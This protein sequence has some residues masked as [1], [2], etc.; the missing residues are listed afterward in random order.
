M[1]K[2][3]SPK[4]SHPS[5]PLGAHATS[6]MEKLESCRLVF[7]EDSKETRKGRVEKKPFLRNVKEFTEGQEALQARSQI[8]KPMMLG[9]ADK[10]LTQEQ[11]HASTVT[12]PA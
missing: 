7:T 2:W 6:A 5:K 11:K 10:I 4:T 3:I 12:W 8:S 9:C 1:H